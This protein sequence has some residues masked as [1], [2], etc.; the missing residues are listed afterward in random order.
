MGCKQSYTSC[1]KVSFT[2]PKDYFLSA[3]VTQELRPSTQIR[4]II[5]EL[6]R[7]HLKGNV[8]PNKLE[9]KLLYKKYL[10]PPTSRKTLEEIHYNPKLNFRVI[11]RELEE[12]QINIRFQCCEIPMN[13]VSMILKTSMSVSELKEI[14]RQKG[15]CKASKFHLV[16]ESLDLE[17]DRSLEY[18]DIENDDTVK[19]II[20]LRSVPIGTKSAPPCWRLKNSGLVLEGICMNDR[21]MAYKQRVSTVLGFG[22]FDIT[23]ECNNPKQICSMC[24]SQFRK[25]QTFGFVNCSIKCRAVMNDGIIQIYK[26]DKFGYEEFPKEDFKHCIQLNVKVSEKKYSKSKTTSRYASSLSSTITRDLSCDMDRS[27]VENVS[28]CD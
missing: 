25:I 13:T 11:C 15:V 28:F 1:F 22:D 4:H 21:C 18:Y 19:V 27:R 16:W 8:S 6:K 10:Y 17:D 5:Q 12:E 9:V 14:L 23:A 26:E 24:C 3:E 2:L 20:N 7:F